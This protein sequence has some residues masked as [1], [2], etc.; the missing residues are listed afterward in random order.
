MKK[1]NIIIIILLLI[2]CKN[3]NNNMQ[4]L[5][6]DSVNKNLVVKY[7]EYFNAHDWEKMAGMYIENAEFKDPSFGKTA[8]KQS[9]KQ[10]VDKYKEL[11]EMFPDLKDEIINIYPSGDNHVIVEFM[12]KGTSSED[13]STF[14]LPICTIFYF[15]NGMIAKDFTYYDNF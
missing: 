6:N 7:F 13:K 2:S 8:I 10:V 4:N 15:E 9:R 12:S 1:I 14:E 5:E 11:A 3:K